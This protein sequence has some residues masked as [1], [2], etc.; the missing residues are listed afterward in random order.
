MGTTFDNTIGRIGDSI[1]E[2]L[3]STATDIF[4]T[5]DYKND[6]EDYVNDIEMAGGDFTP[7]MEE[8]F[9]RKYYKDN[10]SKTT[11]KAQMLAASP[12]SGKQQATRQFATKAPTVQ[13]GRSNFR[14]IDPR[15]Y[16][17]VQ[18]GLDVASLEGLLNQSNANI[19][20][21]KAKQGVYSR[22]FGSRG[23][24]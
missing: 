22:I 15:S 12:P 4:E 8:S 1:S 11:K 14:N 13:S 20:S 24:L 5:E 2:S 21:G 17:Q 18:R 6:L 16:N 3:S 19:M 23:L 7:E 9:K 10:I